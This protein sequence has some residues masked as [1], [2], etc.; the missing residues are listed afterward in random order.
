MSAPVA[1][2][3]SP[4]LDDAA[5]SAGGLLARLAS[6]GWRT[7]VATLFTGNVTRPTGFA[8]ACQ[9]DKG[10]PPHIDYMALRRAEDRAAL[11]HFGAEPLHLPLLEAP[12]RGY[13]SPRQLFRPPHARDPVRP[14]LAPFLARLTATLRPALILA[15]RA[16]GAHVDHVLTHEALARV[17]P[18][19]PILWWTDWPYADRTHAP[20]PFAARLPP[21]RS[22]ALNPVSR[23]AK[24]AACAAYQSQL[25]FQ[26]GGAAALKQRLAAQ[27]R[28]FYAL[29]APARPHAPYL[30]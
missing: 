20:D 8:L 1:L 28:E 29:T 17:A 5:F 12:H 21:A 27:R 11:S 24:A 18:P 6:R 15:P 4:H 23:A 30:G 14:H 19:V 25:G 26:F 16:L 2:A 13:A 3:I 22:L 10:L 9:L 7:I